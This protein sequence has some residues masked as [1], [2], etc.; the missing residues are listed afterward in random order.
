[1]AN[2]YSS[3]FTNLVFQL[4]Y[5]GIIDVVLPFF[6]IFSILYSVLRR[7]KLFGD[8]KS[9]DIVVSLIMSVLTVVP[10]ITGNYPGN[11]DQKSQLDFIQRAC[12]D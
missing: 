12:L 11:Y 5:W 6:L 2:G 10:H 4:E 1:M 3:T 7:L 8:N 9:V